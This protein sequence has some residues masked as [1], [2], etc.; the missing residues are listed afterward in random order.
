MKAPS[1]VSPEGSKVVVTCSTL[2][3]PLRG[4]PSA[5]TIT[6][7]LSAAPRSS[8]RPEI[9]PGLAASSTGAISVA[10]SAWTF[11][12]PTLVSRKPSFAKVTS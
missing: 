4:M 12:S 6:P 2:R 8:T 10:E 7:L 11:T 1:G 9:E 5:V 3:R